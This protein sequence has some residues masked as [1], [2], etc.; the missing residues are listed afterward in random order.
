MRN[1]PVRGPP[2]PSPT[3]PRAVHG[4]P[5]P[6]Q[7]AA[8]E[9][10]ILAEHSAPINEGHFRPAA[11]AAS[12]AKNVRSTDKKAPQQKPAEPNQRPHQPKPKAPTAVEKSPV[13]VES[14][15]KKAKPRA[16]GNSSIPGTTSTHQTTLDPPNRDADGPASPYDDPKYFSPVTVPDKDGIDRP[17]FKF[18]PHPETVQEQWAEYRYGL[19]DQPPVEQLEAKYRAKWRSSAYARSWFT[20][21]KTFWE[22]IKNMLAEGKTEAEAL[23]AMEKRAEGSLPKLIGLLCKERTQKSTGKSITG[24][25]AESQRKRKRETGPQ[26]KQVANGNSD[27][28]D[29][30]ASDS[31]SDGDSQKSYKPR[32]VKGSPKR[33]H[34]EEPRKAG[35]H[36]VGTG[37]R[38][39][40]RK[41][42]RLAEKEAGN[43]DE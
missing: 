29:F 43:V 13:R 27:E 20:R 30:I 7:R 3:P 8:I 17:I 2:S 16:E 42:I 31:A 40:L 21:R 22:K 41:R 32:T 6:P 5:S 37:P 4:Q 9:Q 36:A 10:A 39:L 11:N 34:P 23:S 18:Y 25:S 35:S 15:V 26:Q 24:K 33:R 1:L 38:A 19:H 14:A 28:E 12:P